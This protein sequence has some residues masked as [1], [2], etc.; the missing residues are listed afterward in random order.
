MR[1]KTGFP[2]TC[3]PAPRPSHVQGRS[4]TQKGH[5]CPFF[6]LTWLAPICM[7]SEREKERKHLEAG[8]SRSLGPH[9][10]S[11]YA[12]HTPCSPFFLSFS[13]LKDEA[14]FVAGGDG[15]E[16]EEAC[17]TVVSSHGPRNRSAALSPR[18]TPAFQYGNHH[19]LVEKT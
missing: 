11:F 14:T 10:Q 17:A 8:V 7:I 13:G 9:T 19:S 1:Q 15:R 2:R 16:E 5:D 4:R 6:P 3:C 18:H 12:W